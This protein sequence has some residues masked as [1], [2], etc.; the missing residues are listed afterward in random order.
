[1]TPSSSSHPVWTPAP[2]QALAERAALAKVSPDSVRAEIRQSWQ[3]CVDSGLDPAHKRDYSQ[4]ERGDLHRL[5]EQN[6]RLMQFA[7]RELRKLQ[8]QIPG[9]NYVIAFANSDAVILNAVFH[10]SAPDPASEVAPGVCWKESAFG[11]NAIGLAAIE[12]RPVTVHA[13][14]HFFA[15]YNHLTCTAAPVLAPDGDVAGILDVSSDSKS[16]R[17]HMS[18]LVCMSALQIEAELFR[19]RCQNHIIL[20]FHNRGEFVDTL[21]AGLIAVTD[22]GEILHTN[23]RARFFLEDLPLRT[24]GSFEEIF[25]SSFADFM[26]RCGD[27]NVLTNL[28]DLKGSCYSVKVHAPKRM[29]P[30]R[31]IVVGGTP[32]VPLLGNTDFVYDDPRVQQ[33]LTTVSQAVHLAVPILIRGETGTGKELLARYAHSQ[34]ARPGKFVAVNCAAIPEDLIES[35]LFGYKEGAFTGARGGGS[36]GLVMQAQH[37]TLFLDEIGDMPLRLQPALLRFLDQHTIRPVGST[38]EQ[39]VD[40]QIVAATHCDLEKAVSE[41]QFRADLWHRISSV[42]VFLPP[43]RERTDFREVVLFNLRLIAPQVSITEEALDRLRTYTW[44]GNARELKNV[45]TRILISCPD[46]VITAEAVNTLLNRF[47]PRPEQPSFQMA[48][49][50]SLD[51]IRDNAILEA[52]HKFGGNVSKTARYLSMSRNTVYRRVR[53][54]SH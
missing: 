20:Q 42:E 34:C 3:R 14:E 12:K 16:R 51:A 27:G 50:P 18:A 23:S 37:G 52:Y 31:T 47:A 46:Q 41:R 32:R 29:R 44:P 5:Q 48:A 53:D 2:C 35:E 30:K 33:V 7:E 19:E 26:S 15:D 10:N 24:D 1:M 9:S 11:T 8:A 38:V 40:V 36:Q 49:P 21:Q 28:A 39:Q 54:I 22:T 25:R 45:L 17:Q 43:L 6:G 4:L 13:W